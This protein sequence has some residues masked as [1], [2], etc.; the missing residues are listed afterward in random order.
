LEYNP[1]HRRTFIELERHID[2]VSAA[3]EVGRV[4]REDPPLW[5]PDH[6]KASADGCEYRDSIEA[7]EAEAPRFSSISIA[8]TTY[9]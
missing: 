5:N 4:A 7:L 2:G 6:F 1:E 3:L 8:F 9:T